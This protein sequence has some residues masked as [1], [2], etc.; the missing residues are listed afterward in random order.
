LVRICRSF[1]EA[2]ERAGLEVRDGQWLAGELALSRRRA[3][4]DDY[5]RGSLSSADYFARM[6]AAVEERYTVAELEQVHDAWLMEEYEGVRELVEALNAMPGVR[7]A[8][9]SNTNERHWGLLAPAQPG[10][11]PSVG[12]LKHRFASHLL[13]ANKPEPAAYARTRMDLGVDPDQI[14]FFDDLEENVASAIEQGWHAEQIDS[15][16]QPV[17]QMLRALETHEIAV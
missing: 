10:R 6:S 16:S 11:Y 8:C 14:L 5:Q 1:A 13:G 12:G 15:R 17:H 7:T 9:L 3:I 4:I 2:C